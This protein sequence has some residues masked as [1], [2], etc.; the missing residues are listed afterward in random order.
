[1]ARLVACFV[2]FAAAPALL[3]GDLAI[4]FARGYETTSSLWLAV[5]GGCA[6]W[7]GIALWLV[8]SARRRETFRRT[9]PRFAALAI[10][11]CLCWWLME[12]CLD[13]VFAPRMQFH[14]APAGL[15]HTFRARPEFIRGVSAETHYTANSLGVRGPEWPER[16][17][18][19][20]ILCVGGSTTECLL[21]DDRETWPQLVAERLARGG[22]PVCWVGDVGRSGYATSDHLRLLENEALLRQV[23]DVVFLVGIND[24]QRAMKGRRLDT[25][26]GLRPL[27][28]RSV[29]FR[30]I[31]QAQNVRRTRRRHLEESQDGSNYPLRRQQR[32]AARV[33]TSPPDL[34]PARAQYHRNLEAIADQCA[35]LG[36]RAWFVTQPVL[37]REH[38]TAADEATLWLGLFGDDSRPGTA[39]LAREMAAFNDELRTF[40]RERNLGLV[41]LAP[42][43]G[44]PACFYDDCHFTRE[45]AARVAEL[46]AGGLRGS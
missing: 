29:A 13:A 7:L 37:W 31:D 23:D 21:L 46:V 28:E 36:V 19:R 4:T 5:A 35:R 39:W 17:G 14:L 43:D 2:V 27:Y 1:M 42:L 45:G 32:A 24:L 15:H 33:E 18:A 10:T 11:L 20:R 9:G 25:P 3:L 30:L 34:G 26:F 8:G 6:A 44:D 40:C 22:G 38:I 41:D 16:G 12:V